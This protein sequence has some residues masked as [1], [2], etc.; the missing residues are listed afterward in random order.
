SEPESRKEWMLDLFAKAAKTHNRNKEF[1]FWR[2]GNHSEEVYSNKFLW[3]KLDYI[4]LNP[5]RAGWVNKASHYIYSSASNYVEG[6]GIL[7]ITLADNP[8][9]DVQSDNKFWNSLSW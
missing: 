3:S 6:N 4:H 1:Q 8:V 2:Y 9:I 7:E 5:I